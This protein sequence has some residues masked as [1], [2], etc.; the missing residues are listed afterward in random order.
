MN[1]LTN[2]DNSLADVVGLNNRKA[3]Q[4][5]N[6]TN[7]SLESSNGSPVNRNNNL[8]MNGVNNYTIENK[9]NLGGPYRNNVAAYNRNDLGN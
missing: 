8:L 7:L 5:L 3:R 6:N 2:S 9:N 1:V 4:N